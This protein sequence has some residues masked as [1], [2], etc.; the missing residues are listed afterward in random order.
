MK[1][2]LLR[3]PNTSTER[4]T[5]QEGEMFESKAQLCAEKSIVIKVGY[6]TAY[7]FEGSDKGI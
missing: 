7:S 3:L 2:G 6:F 1:F 4:R 5:Q